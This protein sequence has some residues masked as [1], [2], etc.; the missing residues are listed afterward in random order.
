M[1]KIES[2]CKEFSE[3]VNS[4]ISSLNTQ[5]NSH[6]ELLTELKR[7][8]KDLKSVQDI[9]H[10]QLEYVQNALELAEFELTKIKQE[11]IFVKEKISKNQ[12]TFDQRMDQFQQNFIMVQAQRSK[13]TEKTRG[14]FRELI[15]KEVDH[16][17]TSI[18]RQLDAK[19]PKIEKKLSKQISLNRGLSQSFEEL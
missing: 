3:K 8:T 7:E 11:N 19:L 14:D 18:E 1:P 15:L 10:G 12:I 4:E 2:F 16:L 6:T 5:Q 13:E 9:D 17:R